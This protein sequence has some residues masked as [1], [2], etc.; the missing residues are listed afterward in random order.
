MNRWFAYFV[1]DALISIGSL[2]DCNQFMTLV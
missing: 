2:V 1:L